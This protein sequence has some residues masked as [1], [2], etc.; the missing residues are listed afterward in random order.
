[1]NVSQIINL[2][3]FY[4]GLHRPGEALAMV[5]ELGPM[6]PFGRMQLEI[7]KLEIALQ[8]GDRAAVAT[9]LAYMREHRADAIATW[10]SAL[11]VAGDLDAAADLLVERLDHE[12]WR[13]AALDDMQ[14]YADM[15]L[16]PVDAQC[17]QRWR[18]II[19]R[20]A[21][22]QALAKVGRVEHFNLDPEQ[23]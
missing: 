6:S 18:A 22:Q 13:S 1:M 4:A 20:P 11:L 5:S 7:V 14:Q 8:Q 15:R 19:A 16:T 9:H 23:T 21:V 17:L 3:S 2:G 10:Q 12:E